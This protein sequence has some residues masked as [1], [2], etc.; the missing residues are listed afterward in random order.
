[1]VVG[2]RIIGSSGGGGG[3]GGAKMAVIKVISLDVT[4]TIIG[5]RKPIGKIYADAA[6]WLGL[7]DSDVPSDDLMTKAFYS[8]FKEMSKEH[9]IYGHASNR[10]YRGREWWRATVEKTFVNA[11]GSRRHPNHQPPPP[12]TRVQMDMLFRRIYQE[13]ACRETYDL[14]PDAVKFFDKFQSIART[15]HGHSRKDLRKSTSNAPPPPPPPPLTS[16]SSLPLTLTLGITTNAPLRTVE[17]ILPLL[18]C[19]RHFDWSVTSEDVGREKPH[20]DIFSRTLEMARLKDPSV[21]RENVLHIGDHFLNDFC[22]A[23][24]FGFEAL[25]L[26]RDSPA[27]SETDYDA[28]LKKYMENREKFGGDDCN[29]NSRNSINKDEIQKRTIRKLDESLKIFFP[30]KI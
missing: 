6:K 10:S 13:F 12:L 28:L 5:Y 4:D 30:D 18:G 11:T 20:R 26:D 8:S 15:S 7:K 22:G 2:S 3:G 17:T 16:S 1:M 14:L 29:S 9:P 24:S 23:R 27:E 21:R 19:H 25:Y